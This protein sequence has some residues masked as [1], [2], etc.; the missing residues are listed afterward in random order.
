MLALGGGVLFVRKSS[1]FLGSALF[2]DVGVDSATK[3][4]KSADCIEAEEAL[5][6]NVQPSGCVA[7]FGN[8]HQGVDSNFGRPADERKAEADNHDFGRGLHRMP[9]K[10]GW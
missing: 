6:E 5:S 3:E 4:E 10:A 7:G 9:F 2:P 1:F 8:V